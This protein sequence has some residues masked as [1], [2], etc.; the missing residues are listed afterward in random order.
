[1]FALRKLVYEVSESAALP[2]CKEMEVYMAKQG[3]I[4]TLVSAVWRAPCVGDDQHQLS[5]LAP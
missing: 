4:A 1:M 3:W 2:D 5:F